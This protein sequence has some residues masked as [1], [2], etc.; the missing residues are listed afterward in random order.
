[1]DTRAHELKDTLL[2]VVETPEHIQRKGES[3]EF[4]RGVERLK[5]DGHYRC[6]IC[7]SL[8]DLQTHHLISEW[9]IWNS[10]DPSKLFDVA[11][12]FDPYGY[13][14]SPE[15]AGKPVESVDDIRNFMVLCQKHHT[16]QV[17]GIHSTTFSAWISQKIAKDG[18]EIV[19]QDHAEIERI[20]Q[21]ARS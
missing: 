8:E 13:S 17:T 19:P 11:A 3:A 16:G 10:V 14:R 18:V 2:E 21:E 5:V 6:W 20:E 7:G 4:H 12:I 15:F 1:M 9:S